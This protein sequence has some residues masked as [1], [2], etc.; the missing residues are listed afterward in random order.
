VL[1]AFG[2]DRQQQ[3]RGRHEL[4]VAGVRAPALDAL[5]RARHS[6]RRD[7]FGCVCVPFI[8][9]SYGVSA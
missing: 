6:R 4:A 3:E 1:G 8:R 5:A 9:P 2:L 7:A